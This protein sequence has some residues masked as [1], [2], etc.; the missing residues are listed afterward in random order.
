MTDITNKRIMLTGGSG[1][2]GRNLLEHPVFSKFNVSAPG[3]GELDLC[4]Y[5]AVKA[6]ILANKPDII[7]HSAGRVG[8]IQANL[9]APSAFLIENMD[10]GRNLVWAAKDC[11]IKRLINLGT[12]CMYP[13]NAENPLKE[14]MILQGELEPTNEGYAIAKI[15]VARLCSYISRENPDFRYKTIIPCNLYGRWDKFE[16]EHSHMIPAVIR[17]LHLAKAN[18]DRTIAIWGDGLA[19]R[20]FMY[21]GDIADCICR[22]ITDFDSL[23]EVMNAGIGEDHSIN[24][25]YQAVAEI[26]GYRGSFTHDLDKPA[27]MARKLVD[28]S[29]QTSWGWYP[30]TP[31]KE[32]IARSYEVFLG[33]AT[34][35]PR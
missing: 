29:R 19:R 3:S 10:M 34:N 20:E 31:L 5:G 25:Y 1:M 26:V 8:G 2:V 16:P 6:Y 14:E 32:G 12:S 24:E 4:D 9:K 18:G 21:A 23:P 7:V 30:K 13:R 27:G 11:G 22:A 28:V 35:H 33:G 15:V 17:K